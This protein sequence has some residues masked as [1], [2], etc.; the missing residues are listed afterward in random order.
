MDM[1][2]RVNLLDLSQ[3]PENK[4][5][6]AIAKF[7]WQ[8]IGQI[9]VIKL[10]V[11]ILG[12]ASYQIF[13]NLPLNGIGDWLSIWNQWDTP[14]YLN[15]AQYGYQA[16]GEDRVNIA[17]YPLF[18]W[19]IRLG[20]LFAQNYLLSAL[21][22]SGIA[23]IAAGILLEKLV[24]LDYPKHLA[25]YTVWFFLIFPTS[26][27]LH[28]AYTESLFL[29]LTF[30]CLLSAR[31][32][33]W[34][35]AGILGALAS[36]T[37]ING[38]ILF[39]TLLVEVGHQYWITKRF[40]KRWL[41]IGFV[42]LGFGIYLLCNFLVTGNAFTFLIHQHE[43]WHKSGASPWLGIQ[44]TIARLWEASPSYRQMVGVQELL[45][46]GL[47]LAGTIWSWL[48]LRPAYSVWMTGN[49]LLFTSTSFILS[50][51]RYTLVLFPLYI[52][53]ACQAQNRFWFTV[54]N[55]WSLLFF[56]LFVSLFAQG[57]WAF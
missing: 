34:A 12:G 15:L 51:P 31:Q 50:V 43:F 27:F 25:R 47:G 1:K 56:S 23:A 39:P 40:D 6:S 55:V 5:T 22:V 16:T 2:D 48:R 10:A 33:R 32:D 24:R 36:M 11:L 4:L 38:T 18:P 13:L 46:I 26:Y 29:A 52:L 57:K 42:P 19:L 8:L 20:T 44:S 14:R 35:L 37:R 30:G 49:W 41:W 9:L 28:I 3:I 45:F 21:I 17:F 7:D 53:F 54:I